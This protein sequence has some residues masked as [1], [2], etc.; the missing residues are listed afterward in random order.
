MFNNVPP[1]VPNVGSLTYTLLS[2]KTAEATCM[3]KGMADMLVLLC[4]LVVSSEKLA[5]IQQV[6][7]WKSTNALEELSVWDFTDRRNG[8]SGKRNCGRA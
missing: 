4:V 7:S 1:C 8:D 6:N 3:S 5:Y 2:F